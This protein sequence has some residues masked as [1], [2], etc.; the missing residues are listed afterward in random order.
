MTKKE[1][2]QL[3]KLNNEFTTLHNELLALKHYDI[4]LKLSKV[5]YEAQTLNHSSGINFM[6][7]LYKL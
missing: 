5:Y 1:Q 6:K 7:N 2:K 3:D 4:A